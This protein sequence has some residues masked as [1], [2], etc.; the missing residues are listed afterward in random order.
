[1]SPANRHS[2][3]ERR[4]AVA[5]AFGPNG[6]AAQVARDLGV[7]PAT[8]YRWAKQ[9]LSPQE[10]PTVTTAA[11]LIETTLDLLRIRDYGEIT[12][13]EVARTAGVGLRTAFHHFASKRDL[14]HA[15]IDNAATQLIAEMQ[16]RYG[17][18]TWPAQPEQQ[19]RVFLRVA[20]E[21]IYATPAAH[22]LFRDLGVPRKDSFAERW[23][24][25]FERAL[26]ELL[27]CLAEGGALAADVDVEA[28]AGAITAAMRGIHAS[29]FEGV[30]P[31]QA[32]RL[33][34]RLWL[35][36]ARE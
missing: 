30:D 4:A 1:M 28:C 36:V 6:D 8:V 16:R 34:D 21:A 32:I 29:V 10:Q 18:E 31:D 33:V 14:F 26:A 3:E 25:A 22:V 7:H 17:S 12:V 5:R 2:P 27:V 23:H 35:I 20:A 24:E 15:A 19:L 13:E 9:P 11:R